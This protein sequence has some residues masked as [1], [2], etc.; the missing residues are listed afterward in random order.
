MCFCIVHKHP[1]NDLT[2]TRTITSRKMYKATPY[3]ES[4][5]CSCVEFVRNSMRLAQIYLLIQ[6]TF[7]IAP[8]KKIKKM[9][10]RTKL[11][12]SSTNIFEVPYNAKYFISI[13][14]ADIFM[15]IYFNTSRPFYAVA[16]HL[17][18]SSLS[19]MLT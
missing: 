4:Q 2:N 12:T 10:F 19:V 7:N 13:N 18:K 8:I 11:T 15:H 1:M 6:V 3:S 5:V 17:P 9:L 16:V 14:A